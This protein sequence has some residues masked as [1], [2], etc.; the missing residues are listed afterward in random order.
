MKFNV[1]TK[2]DINF[3]EQQIK[4]LLTET[5]KRE[6]PNVDVSGI[7]WV[8]KRQPTSVSAKVDASMKGFEAEAKPRTMSEKVEEVAEK[9][10]E[11][12]EE[13]KETVSSVLNFGD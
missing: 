3:T 12:V 5:V 2:I 11:A 6:M 10:E 8:V 1:D 9:I 4:D 7:E 13:A